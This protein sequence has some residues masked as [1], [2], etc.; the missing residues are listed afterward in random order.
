MFGMQGGPNTLEVPRVVFAN[1]CEV[2]QEFLRRD[3]E[4]ALT[5]E[6]AN[7]V[8]P[9]PGGGCVRLPDRSRA[10]SQ[11]WIRRC[12]APVLPKT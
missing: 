6:H 4:S 1:G 12:A 5:E 10:S 9:G 11:L 2:T 7:L 3:S 8:R